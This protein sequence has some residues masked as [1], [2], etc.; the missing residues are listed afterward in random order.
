MHAKTPVILELSCIE[1]LYRTD[2]SILNSS[3][4]ICGISK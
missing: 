3:N 1:V 2:A 4:Q